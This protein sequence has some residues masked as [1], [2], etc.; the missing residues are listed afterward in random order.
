MMGSNQPST[1][2]VLIAKTQSKRQLQQP[3]RARPPAEELQQP[4][5]TPGVCPPKRFSRFAK[6]MPQACFGNE[7]EFGSPFH[8]ARITQIGEEVLG[9][10]KVFHL[11]INGTQFFQRMSV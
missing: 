1:S 11:D 8:Y 10:I 9:S 3:R 2:S 5:P 7:E 6:L 4:L